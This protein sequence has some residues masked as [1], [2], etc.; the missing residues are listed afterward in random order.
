MMDQRIKDA[1]IV[2]SVSGGKDSAAMSLLL[3]LQGTR[4]W[5]QWSEWEAARSRT[6][7]WRKP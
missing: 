3:K 4:N 2:A 1:V 5:R 7:K 6:D